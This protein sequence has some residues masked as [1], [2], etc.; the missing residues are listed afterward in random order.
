[1]HSVLVESDVAA[2]TNDSKLFRARYFCFA[3]AM[4]SLTYNTGLTYNII[5]HKD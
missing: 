3:F 2:R 1:M 4:E 5:R